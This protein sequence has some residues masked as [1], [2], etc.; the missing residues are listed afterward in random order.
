MSISMRAGALLSP[1]L[2][3]ELESVS[4]RVIAFPN[5]ATTARD[6]RENMSTDLRI[7]P[8][9]ITKAANDLDAIG[10][11]TDGI[12]VPPTPSPSALGGL[13]MSAGNARF[14]RGVDVRRERIRQWHA[15]TS[16]ALNDTSRHS[17]DQDAAW[18]S[19]FR[20][21]IAIPL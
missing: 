9:D 7:S 4:H 6:D 21:D 12:Q 11:A 19:A 13:A 8:D 16:E 5:T 2:Q 10:E 18:A 3:P 14:V 15:M 17:V 20:R 1:R